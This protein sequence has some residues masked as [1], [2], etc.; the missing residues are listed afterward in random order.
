[1]GEAEAGVFLR[2][3]EDFW[4]EVNSRHKESYSDPLGR[5]LWF[6]LQTALMDFEVPGKPQPLRDRKRDPLTDPPERP[7]PKTETPMEGKSPYEHLEEFTSEVYG[8][9]WVTQA[10]EH[11]ALERAASPEEPASSPRSL[12]A[13][14]CFASLLRHKKS[15]SAGGVGLS[16]IPQ[17]EFGES[18]Q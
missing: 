12:P 7:T 18:A 4:C 6:G 13:S 9:G 10:N 14:L 1:M 5:S 15:R 17:L 2:Q 8:Q 11:Q 3:V 16:R